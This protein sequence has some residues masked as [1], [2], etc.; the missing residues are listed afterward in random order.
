MLQQ[1]SNQ[2]A[3][4]NAMNLLNDNGYIV[5][6]PEKCGKRLFTFGSQTNIACQL[7][8]GHIGNHI[9][10]NVGVYESDYQRTPSSRIVRVEWE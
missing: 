10:E 2:E 5:K 8:K 7:L 4:V 9:A 6:T 1:T 3:I